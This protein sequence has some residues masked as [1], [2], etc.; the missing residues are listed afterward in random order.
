MI[1]V[2]DVKRKDYFM[3][4]KVGLFTSVDSDDRNALMGKALSA[5]SWLRIFAIIGLVIGIIASI[6]LILATFGLGIIFAILIIAIQVAIFI[7]TG[8]LKDQIEENIIPSLTPPYVF[9]VLA[10][11]GVLSSFKD[12]SA[13]SIPNILIQLFTVYLWYLVISCVKKADQ[14]I[15]VQTVSDDDNLE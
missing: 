13:A 9:I 15:E 4:E 7:Y 5:A 11:L 14:T 6:V 8:K 3:I 2:C 1:N 10:I 12:F